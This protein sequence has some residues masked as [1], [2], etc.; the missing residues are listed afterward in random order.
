MAIAL[1]TE[2]VRPITISRARVTTTPVRTALD[3]VAGRSRT[4]RR[5]CLLAVFLIGWL[6][7]YV[8]GVLE[9]FAVV[10]PDR[11][12]RSSQLTANAIQDYTI[13]YGLRTIINLRGSNPD[14]SWYWEEIATAERLGLEHYDIGVDSRYPYH[15]EIRDVIETLETCPRPVLLHCNSGVDRTGTMATVALLLLEDRMT[16]ALAEAQFGLR[17]LQLPWRNNA[18]TQRQ[19]FDLYRYWLSE[20]N[21]PHT[22]AN[23]RYWAL[24]VYQRPPDETL[25][26]GD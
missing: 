17:Y 1:L 16:P 3:R 14:C 22:R 15:D 24:D 12:Y 7:W 18:T 5:H 20:N 19:F 25:D 21:L 13:R 6:G 11:I 8:L 4:W 23:F 2:D 10:I 26:Y 9:N